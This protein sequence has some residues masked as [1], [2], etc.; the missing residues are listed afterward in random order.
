M[1]ESQESE[2]NLI[3]GRL[4]GVVLTVGEDLLSGTEH[5]TSSTEDWHIASQHESGR[6][7]RFLTG[8][9]NS[10]AWAI[11]EYRASGNLGDC[12]QGEGG[13]VFYAR[14]KY[15]KPFMV[16]NGEATTLEVIDR[17]KRGS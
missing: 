9:I 8:D 4:D 12:I 5:F 3:G 11:Y 2:I 1:I 17:I 14:Y 15:I 10:T 7:L 13:V 6:T 16:S